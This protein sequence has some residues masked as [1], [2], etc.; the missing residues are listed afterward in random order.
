MRSALLVFVALLSLPASAA[1]APAI[2][3]VRAVAPTASKPGRV[4][5][6][7][8]DAGGR[9]V[10]SV[11]VDTA[12]GSFAESACGVTRSGEYARPGG[13][14]EVPVAGDG[15]AVVTVGNGACASDAPAPETSSQGYTLTFGS[16]LPPL[17]K[18]PDLP[19]LPP[20]PKLPIATTSVAGCKGA[21]LQIR[22]RTRKQ[23]RK[24][25]ICL[26][27]IQ[28][29]AAG[30]RRVRSNLRLQKAAAAHAS[31]M[32]KRAYFAHEGP[33]GPDLVTRLERA[34]FWP[35]TAGENLAAGTGSLATARSIVIA[36]MNSAGHKANMLDGRFK[37]IGIGIEPLFPNPPSS[38]GGTVA[39]EFGV[40]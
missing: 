34:H 29:S 14:F 39:A 33:G 8:T 18:L 10:S 11:R 6:E 26:V 36:W 15:E 40:R 37:Y 38:P 3:L 4:V 5:V 35:A 27:N 23:V 2:D 22:G 32:R 19:T 12:G 9:T 25:I 16:I 17:P 21:D 31:D 28:R 24:A 1:A 30:V 20:L 13:R 7:A